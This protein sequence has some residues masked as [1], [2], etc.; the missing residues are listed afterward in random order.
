MSIRFSD[1]NLSDEAKAHWQNPD[2]TFKMKWWFCTNETHSE[3]IAA[4]WENRPKTHYDGGCWSVIYSGADSEAEILEKCGIPDEPCRE[5]GLIF[6][7]TFV[8]PVKAKLLAQNICHSCNHFRE[9]CKSKNGIRV[10]GGHYLDGG[11]RGGN[12]TWNGF[13]GR[14]FRVRMFD[15]REFETNNMWFQGNIPQ[16]FRE[17]LPDNAEF[18]EGHGPVC[19]SF[20]Q[21]EHP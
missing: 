2:G 3:I 8:E 4:T 19:G 7:T 11:Q 14:I 10:N 13:G 20:L 5:C 1:L 16:H 18:I 17:R 9:L 21:K 12:T 6:A 15:G